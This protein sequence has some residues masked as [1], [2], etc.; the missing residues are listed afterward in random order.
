MAELVRAAAVDLVGAERVKEGELHMGSEDFSF[1]ARA[2]PGVFFNLGAKKDDLTRPH[3]NPV[4]DID[5]NILPT[6]AALLAETARRYLTGERA[7]GNTTVNRGDG[8]HR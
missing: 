3:H 6:G 2:K 5:E 4:F 1:M 8:C 7:H